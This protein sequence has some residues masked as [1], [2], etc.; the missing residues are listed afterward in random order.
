[1]AP[2]RKV[3]TTKRRQALAQSLLALKLIVDRRLGDMVV[4]VRQRLHADADDYFLDLGF[5]ETGVE[6]RLQLVVGRMAT[7][8]DHG[9]GEFK[10]RVEPGAVCADLQ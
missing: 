9:A 2:L 4:V 8:F 7:L 1:M 3:F 5:A 6:E 10:Q